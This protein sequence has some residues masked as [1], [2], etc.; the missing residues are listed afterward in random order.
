MNKLNSASSEASSCATLV[1]QNFI[2]VVIRCPCVHLLRDILV[3][4]DVLLI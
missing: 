1:L 2:K 3:K 4:T